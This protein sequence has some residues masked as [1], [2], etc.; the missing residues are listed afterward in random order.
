MPYIEKITK[1]GNTT[2]VEKYYRNRNTKSQTKLAELISKNFTTGDITLTL[3]YATNN[4]ISEADNKQYLDKFIRSL[5][6]NYRVAGKELKYV[7]VSVYDLYVCN[8]INRV[9]LVANGIGDAARTMETLQDCWNYGKSR[10]CEVQ[11]YEH[12]K[13]IAEHMERVNTGR[14]YI[15]KDIAKAG[16]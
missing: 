12:L 3:S 13:E 6:K 9:E 10:I 16:K 7:A 4:K 15:T 1:A 2:T 8:K 14:Y 5:R 11:S